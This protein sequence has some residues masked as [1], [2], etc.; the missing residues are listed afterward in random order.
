MKFT[1][2]LYDSV[3]DIWPHYLEHPFVLEMAQGIL[4]LEKFRYYMLQDYAY[5]RDYIKIFAA[6]IAKADDFR[7]IRFLC[8]NMTAI[9][10]ETER[11][12]VPYMKRL[13]ITDE[14]IHAV[15]PHIDSSSYSHYMICEAQ[16]G[17]I[18]S[19]LVALLNCSWA[20][21]YIGEKIVQRYPDAPQQLHYG[22]WFSS[23]IC[24]EYRQTN[25]A[26]I[27]MVE[28][29]SAD[30]SPSEREKL[31]RIFRTCSQYELRFWNMVYAAGK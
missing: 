5:L 13:G 25:Q 4:P 14:E 30:I 28:R 8:E 19:G 2:Q 27:D 10:D 23:Y 12:H 1:D 26:L 18:L 24:D 22:Q 21:A 31:C 16:S 20:Y 11:V 6:C 15:V 29:L 3:Q 17:S 7:E 9:L